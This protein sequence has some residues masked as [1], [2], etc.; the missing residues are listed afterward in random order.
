M[1][2]WSGLD[3]FIFLIFLVNMLMGMS[4]GGMKEIISMFAL[5][6][7][8]VFTLKF[9]M[10][11]TEFVNKSPL[12]SDVITSSFFQNFMKSINMPPLTEAIL[13]QL[14]YCISLLICFV[15]AFSVCE[16]VLSYSGMIEAFSLPTALLNRKIGAGLGATRGFVIV[17]VFI[18]VLMHMFNGDVPSSNFVNLLQGS[19]RKMDE[20]ISSHAPERYQEILQN[21]YKFNKDDIVNSLMKPQ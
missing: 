9:T 6:A 17:L 21:A 13:V 3:F 14:G 12:M 1:S 18:I 15:G 8:L 10:P 4:R 2:S 16:G 20:L 19:A 7:A 11:L 5:C